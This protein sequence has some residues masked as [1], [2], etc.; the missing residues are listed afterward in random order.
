[1]TAEDKMEQ[2][3]EIKR[4]PKNRKA[5]IVEVATKLFAERGWSKVTVAEISE[6][7]GISSTAFYKHFKYKEEILFENS[8]QQLN[9]FKIF[10]DNIDSKLPPE[11]KMYIFLNELLSVYSEFGCNE[12]TVALSD[13]LLLSHNQYEF[14]AVRSKEFWSPYFDFF[15]EG[16]TLNIFRK[17]ISSDG[18]FDLTY[19]LIVGVLYSWCVN[20]G[21]DDLKMK[22][23]QTLEIFFAGLKK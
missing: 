8:K 12:I 10:C 7:V 19:P 3:K 18:L 5:Q 1:M 21:V 9:S 17:D 15:T 16:K 13:T 20:K 11:T 14:L 22:F 6:A 4:R 2:N 23:H